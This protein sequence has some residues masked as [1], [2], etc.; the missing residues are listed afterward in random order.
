MDLRAPQ[1][2]VGVDV[3]DSRHH[4][5]VE[6]STF[7]LGVL[8]AHHRNGRRRVESRVQWIPG[9]VRNR[10]G[11]E[12]AVD[13][14]QR[15]ERPSAEGALIHEPQ[16]ESGIEPRPNAQMFLGDGLGWL[17]E[18]LPAHPQVDHERDG[19]G[20]E[21]QPQ[22]LSAAVSSRNSLAGEL[23]GQIRCA[24]K[25]PPDRTGVQDVD[26]IDRSSDNVPFES[27]A[28]YLDLG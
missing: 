2:L 21:D 12:R 20:L 14:D 13:I 28:N 27:A 15:R 3:P 4:R 6:K 7:D 9:D 18:H 25:M 22:V 23:S 16:I 1:G 11:D 10:I 17:H 26:R 8:A 19:T 24:Q 5:L